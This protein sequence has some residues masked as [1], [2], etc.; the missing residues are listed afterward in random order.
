M[1]EVV[2]IKGLFKNA[3]KTT[4]LDTL[5]AAFNKRKGQ[6]TKFPLI[7]SAMAGWSI[8]ELQDESNEEKNQKFQGIYQ[9]RIGFQIF[10][11]AINCITS[12]ARFIDPSLSGV[13]DA[14]NELSSA[15][16]DFLDVSFE[17][18]Q[19]FKTKES[20]RVKIFNFNLIF[21]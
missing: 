2:K 6:L 3:K 19:F 20:D 5:R 1:A 7:G 16:I 8:S 13:A 12:I 21:S 4:M 17:T 9:I 11:I 14:I 15:L 18:Y 10:L